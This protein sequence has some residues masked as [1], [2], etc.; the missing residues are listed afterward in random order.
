[1]AQYFIKIKESFLLSDIKDKDLLKESPQYKK[2][3]VDRFKEFPYDSFEIRLSY[4]IGYLTSG[5]NKGK[6]NLS[7]ISYDFGPKQK[8]K[9]AII[10]ISPKEKDVEFIIDGVFKFP[11]KSH[12]EERVQKSIFLTFGNIHYISPSPSGKYSYLL[13]EITSGT[14]K[15]PS[16]ENIKKYGICLPINENAKRLLS[17]YKISLFK[18]DLQ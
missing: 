8:T 5:P 14:L 13:G 2:P 12:H 16:K 1:M 9:G 10:A 15:I 11:V 6:M 3:I 4:E 18:D 7:H 17:N